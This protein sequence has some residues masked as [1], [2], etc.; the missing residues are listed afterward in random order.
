MSPTQVSTDPPSSTTSEPEQLPLG[1]HSPRLLSLLSRARRLRDTYRRRCTAARRIG[2]YRSPF[3]AQ[4][5]NEAAAQLG[6][7]AE[8]LGKDI[9]Q[10]RLG[11][12]YTRVRYNHTSLDDSRTAET[13]YQ[14]PLVYRLLADC[15]LSV[16]ESCE[17][18]LKELDKAAAFLKTTAGE[19]VVKPAR[20]HGGFGV[21]TS[22]T[23]LSQ[24]LWGA[25][26]AA[27]YSP[28]CVIERQVQGDVYR[29]LYLDGELL[30]AVL[31]RRPTVTGDGVSNI[32]QLVRREN[33]RRLRTGLRTA[34]I[35]LSVDADMRNT[36]GQQGLNLWSAPA[37]GITVVLKT[38][39][40]ENCHLEN[41]SAKKLLCPAIVRDGM[42]AAAVLGI[43]LAGVDLITTDPSVP[44]RQSGGAIVDV[45]A[46]PGLHPHYYRQDGGC[47][48]AV[49]ILRRL[50]DPE[51]SMPRTLV[52]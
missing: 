20:G 30:D 43:Q 7:T 12:Q 8:H 36:L 6:A 3:Y 13:S 41:V 31:R 2:R 46:H 10:I 37:D 52:A 17:F 50:L 51:L 49:P 40:N 26:A 42:L 11:G 48:V 15:R 18:S 9:W 22:I 39:S 19:C 32:R 23:H 4:V 33:Q 14:K 5:W 25:V 24:L 16:P 27:A 45:N 21:T 38:A 47:S 1:F 44:L 29:L 28:T 34:H 35:A